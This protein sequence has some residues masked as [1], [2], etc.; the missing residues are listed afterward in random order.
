MIACII[1]AY[2]KD[3]LFHIAFIALIISRYAALLYE[4]SAQP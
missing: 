2:E 3:A 1:F 4:L